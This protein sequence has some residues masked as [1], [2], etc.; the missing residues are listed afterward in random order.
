MI[1]KREVVD[2]RWLVAAFQPPNL[3]AGLFRKRTDRELQLHQS[4]SILRTSQYLLKVL[5]AREQA[6]HCQIHRKHHSHEWHRFALI[7]GTDLNFMLVSAS[8]VHSFDLLS[9]LQLSE[10]VHYHQNSFLPLMVSLAI[11]YML[12]LYAISSVIENAFH[13][14]WFA[15]F[16]ALPSYS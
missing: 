8:R 16:A 3:E 15:Y 9:F 4:N 6:S 7:Y 12:V 14:P 10:I 1:W 2:S 5:E 13:S 11:A